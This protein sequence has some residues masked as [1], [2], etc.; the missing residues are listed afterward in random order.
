MRRGSDVRFAPKN[1]ADIKFRQLPVL[2]SEKRLVGIVSLADI[3]V[4]K[5]R[6]MPVA[7]YL[8]FQNRAA[9]IRSLSTPAFDKG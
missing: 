2:N 6:K 8:A 9:S 1:M 5:G 4:A 7:H 3:A